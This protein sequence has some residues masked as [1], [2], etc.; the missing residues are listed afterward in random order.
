MP[1]E[2]GRVIVTGRMAQSCAPQTQRLAI[3]EPA[4]YAWGTF[5]TLWRQQGVCC[6]CI[7]LQ[8]RPGRIS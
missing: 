7:T 5:V 1:T 4:D 2:P 3:M 6:N 8:E